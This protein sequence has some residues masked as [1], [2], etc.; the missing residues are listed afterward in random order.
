[1]MRKFYFPIT[2]SLFPVLS[3]LA[4]NISQVDVMDAL[5]AFIVSILIACLVY[6]LMDIWLRD[7]LRAAILSTFLLLL[8][9]SYGHIYALVE[10]FTIFSFNIGRHR[11]LI[12]IWLIAA[13]MGVRWV[14][15][16]QKSFDQIGRALNVTSIILIVIPVVQIL[17]FRFRSV[18]PITAKPSSED[19][20]VDIDAAETQLIETEQPDALPD[21]YYIIL[22]MYTRQDVLRS[23]LGFDNSEFIDRLEDLGFYVASCGNSNYTST[24]LSLGATLNLDYFQDLVGEIDDKA[25]SPYSYGE[26]VKENRLVEI[27]KQLGYSVVSFE[28]GFSPTEWEDAAYYT[29]LGEN[30]ILG[31][32]NPFEVMFFKTTMGLFLFEFDDALP[33]AFQAYYDSAY[34]QHRDRILMELDGIADTIEIPGPKF[35]FAHIL[36]PHNPFVFGPNGEFIRRHTPFTLNI[37]TESDNWNEFAPGYIGQIRY[38]NTR[39]EAIVSRI[40][41][42]SESPT[43]IIIQ[44]D[45]GIPTIIPDDYKSAILNAIYLP[46]AGREALYPSISSVNTFR[47]VLDAYFGTNYGLLDDVSYY[48]TN[49]KFPFQFEVIRW[50]DYKCPAE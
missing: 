21:V 9:Y 49:N 6:A 30:R 5:R 32:M 46:D 15:S 16:P 24:V 3:L 26:L 18:E 20:G 22:D 48:S 40:L 43:V 1:M 19:S 4:T 2:L 23:K 34:I 13:Y 14:R 41:N 35:V 7:A 39:V 25:T 42:E 17:A 28:S 45:H 12:L 27:F 11:F 33:A 44:G 50:D 8:F 36:A 47:L 29:H 37:D 31:G 10:D 38:L